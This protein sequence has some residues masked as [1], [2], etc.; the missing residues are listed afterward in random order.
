MENFGN[1]ANLGRG[2]GTITGSHPKFSEK[3]SESQLAINLLA[4]S[5]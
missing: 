5:T 1:Q 4:I 2:G 3:L